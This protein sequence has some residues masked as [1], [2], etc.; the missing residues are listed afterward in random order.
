MMLMFFLFF[1]PYVMRSFRIMYGY[2]AVMPCY[3]CITVGNPV[4][5]NCYIMI[6]FRNFPVMVFVARITT[7]ANYCLPGTA[8]VACIACSNSSIM[9]P[10]IT[11]VYYHFVG[12][13]FIKMV[14]F[15][16]I[17]TVHPH[18]IFIIN[19]LVISNG[20]ICINVGHVI[21]IGMVIAYRAPVGLAANI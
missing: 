8:P 15:G 4:I 3:L 20:I 1:L 6:V 9:F 7:V 19:I 2:P 11:L 13:I 16:L 12:I 17:S 21:I 18:V 10:W 14:A 5:V